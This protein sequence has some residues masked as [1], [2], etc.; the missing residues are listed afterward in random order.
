MIYHVADAAVMIY[1]MADD[2]CGSI[3]DDDVDKDIYRSGDFSKRPG[4]KCHHLRLSFFIFVIIYI[5]HTV[6]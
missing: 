5:H 4:S 3:G 2:S 6:T 1:H